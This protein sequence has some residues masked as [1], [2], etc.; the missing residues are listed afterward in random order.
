[1]AGCE[2]Y[3]AKGGNTVGMFLTFF[4]ET[5]MPQ[6]EQCEK[7]V[8]KLPTGSVKN[9]ENCGETRHVRTYT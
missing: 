3:V 8:V 2:C 1:M 5:Q 7:N 6:M 9:E 4:G